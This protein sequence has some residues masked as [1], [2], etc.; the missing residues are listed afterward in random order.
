VFALTGAIT[1]AAIPLAYTISGPL[2]D[3]IFEPA[4]MPG[5]A[6]AAIAGPLVGQGP[7]RGVALL[8]ATAGVLTLFVCLLA[9]GFSP[10]RRLEHPEYA[11]AVPATSGAAE[12]TPEPKPK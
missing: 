12:A 6:L 5:H 10:L 3:R 9:A 4:M 8:F 7:G 1:Q 2:A 11:P